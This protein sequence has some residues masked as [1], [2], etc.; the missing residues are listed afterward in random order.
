MGKSYRRPY[1]AICGNSSA[2]KDK[3]VAARG[4]RRKQNEWL[5]INW[6]EEEMGLIPHRY[7]CHH[8]SVWDWCRDGKQRLCVPRACDWSEYCRISQGLFRYSGE[9]FWTRKNVWPPHWAVE[10]TRK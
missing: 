3:Q 10:V 5:R 6:H 4:V 2:K 8:N 1:Q 7:E 9:Q